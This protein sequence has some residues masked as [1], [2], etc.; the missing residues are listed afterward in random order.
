M[1]KLIIAPLLLAA[2]FAVIGGQRPVAAAPAAPE[3]GACRFYCN[4]GVSF[5]TLSACQ[6]VCRPECEQI[7]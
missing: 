2:L 4:N 7:C 6:A 3:F 1:K 5:T